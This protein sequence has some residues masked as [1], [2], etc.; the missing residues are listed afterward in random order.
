MRIALDQENMASVQNQMPISKSLGRNIRGLH[1]KTPHNRYPKTSF[2]NPLQDENQTTIFGKKFGKYNDNENAENNGKNSALFDKDVFATPIGP[3]TRAPLGAKTTNAKAK[4]LQ[5]PS[6][7]APP[8]EEHEF[9]QM[10]SKVQ[11]FKNVTHVNINNLEIEGKEKPLREREVEYC[12]PKP[13]DLPY[14]SDTFPDNCIDYSNIHT[15]NIL[16]DLQ[17]SHLSHIIDESGRSKLEQENAKSYQEDI[18]E[19]DEAILRMMEEEWTVNDRFEN[20]VLSEKKV[21]QGQLTNF[22]AGG[23]IGPFSSGT[24]LCTLSARRAAAILS[25]TPTSEDRPCQRK[26]K[27]PTPTPSFLSKYYPKSNC[28]SKKHIN[29]GKTY[30]ETRHIRSAVISKSTIGYSKGREVPLN[31]HKPRDT[32][33]NSNRSV[34]CLSIGSDTT[35]TPERFELESELRDPY[36]LEIFKTGEEEVESGLLG[37]FPD[38]HIMDEDDECF[39]I[40]PSQDTS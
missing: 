21:P 37:E 16:R 33:R 28:H 38:H 32:Q 9:P 35:V 27:L 39:I 6:A 20:T 29:S 3:R 12:P 24:G 15:K 26:S 10:P 14:Q 2:Q 25:C 17:K 22:V 19:V 31:L 1:P 30:P 11:I 23:Q 5:T 36:F 4:V 8:K 34:S 13:K 40:L 18:K 7:L